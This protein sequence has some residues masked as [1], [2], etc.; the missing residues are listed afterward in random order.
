MSICPLKTPSSMSTALL[1]FVAVGGT[2]LASSMVVLFVATEWLGWHY[3]GGSL[4]AVL[5]PVPLSWWLNR[6]F[7]FRSRAAK[8]PEFLRFGLATAL[9][10]LIVMAGM[11]WLVDVMGFPPQP[12]MLGLGAAMALL[13]FVAMA[14]FVYMR[15]VAARL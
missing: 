9:H 5:A 15:P 11:Y 4:L 10:Y 8:G 13:N 12:S 14:V 2:C 1:R 3:L 6:R 7:T